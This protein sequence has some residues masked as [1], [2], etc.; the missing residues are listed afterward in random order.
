MPVYHETGEVQRMPFKGC[1]KERKER[2]ISGGNCMGGKGIATK[3]RE[4]TTFYNDVTTN[5]WFLNSTI[6]CV[7]FPIE[8]LFSAAL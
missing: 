5:E 1:L 7:R 4:V 6:F 2:P 3:S 8:E